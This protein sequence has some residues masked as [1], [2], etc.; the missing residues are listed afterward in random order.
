VKSGAVFPPLIR[1][2]TIFRRARIERELDT[3][4]LFHLDM[5]AAE[6]VRQGMSPERARRAARQLFGGIEQV[7]DDVRD[8]WLTRLIE[9]FLQDARYSIRS[10]RKHS[11]Y[12]FAVIATMALGIGANS[13]IFS[14]VNA[15]LLQPLPYERG[16]DLVL[17]RQQQS[18]VENRGF[19]I[20]DIDDIK[21]M[22]TALDAIVEY[23][24]MY[25][26][27]L[28]GDEPA[29]VATGV[30]SWDYF[31]ALGVKPLLGRTFRTS[32]DAH[33]AEAALVLSYE[34]W[35]RALKGDPGVI[36][37]VFEMN[38]R[39]HTVVGVLPE[40]PM[41]PEAND[42]YMPR[43]A[44][45]F[46]M[47]PGG[48]DRR[49]GGLA[50]A[51]GR[52]RA[53]VT[54]EQTQAD[55][56]AIEDRLRKSYPRAYPAQRG[57]RLTATPLRR[58]FTRGFESRLLFLLSTAGFVLLIVCASVA[59]L[60][61]ART[62]R[63]D[64]EFAL[65]TALGASRLRLLR[66]LTTE[67]VMLSL[68][69]GTLGLIL[70]FAG[71]DLLVSYVERFTTRATEIRVDRMVLLFTLG[72]S[73]VAGVLSGTLPALSQRLRSKPGGLTGPLPL[74]R[75]DVRR[76]LITAQVAASFMLLIG[77]GLMLRSL[78][79]LTGVDPGFSA[80]QVLTM[81]ID[82]NFSK[83]AEVKERAAYLN[84]LLAAI[85]DVPGVSVAGAAGTIPFLEHSGS[86]REGFLIQGRPV[87]DEERRPEAA[88]MFASDDYF[89]AMNIPLVRGRFSTGD[90][91]LE[92][93]R[94]AIVNRS[95]A[96]R[97]W[98]DA[99]PIGQRISGDGVHW[100][101]IV[102]VIAD[103]R[104]QLSLEP[105]EEIYA[106]MAQMP[107]LTTNWAI[108][109][110]RDLAE[111]APLVRAAVYRVDPGQ[112]IYRMRPLNDVRA[113]SLA[114]SRLT[115]ALLGIFAMLAL[116]ITATGIAG[117]IAFSV[118][119]RTQEFGVR[120]A[121]GAR[122]TD[123]VSMVVREGVRLAITGLAL[124]TIGA[125][126]MGELFSTMLFG[127]EP[128]DAVTY[129]TVSSVLLTVAAL[130]CLLPALRAAAVDPMQALRTA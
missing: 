12:A 64:H 93:P 67:S 107:Y 129:I 13:A 92:T 119:Q 66:Q 9:A 53:G 22:S 39:P 29:R 77:A 116:V 36:G 94:V 110:T 114:P 45:P 117:V 75:Q 106:P 35:Q 56:T 25:F 42:V 62:L 8:T 19:S 85:R 123:V 103:V 51:F 38:D 34:Y 16:D 47:S 10:L 104:Q 71:R 57:H 83:Y 78:M 90:D 91:T 17:L 70:A 97:Y 82:V 31:D 24:N 88:V 11:G 95:L 74:G 111:L 124:G 86:W 99:D 1:L 40:I 54:M 113:A 122:H 72:I 5:Q 28:G 43:S 105:I 23:H 15:V 118:S 48:A 52:R 58:E 98:P 89:R 101:T 3:E 50:S 2:R 6:Y 63:R 7:K 81:Q 121:L 41:Y 33:G 73:L 120:V 108:R 109:S 130:A 46:R 55:L 59:N 69:G 76:A 87:T 32:D 44:C 102:G 61:M 80:D 30:V 68:A 27:L 26:I 126:V 79:K 18:Q 4:L 115:A 14:V 127:V 112:P 84:R 65:R 125:L 128:T 37:R 60:S 20:K 100:H 49:G 96:E 21:A